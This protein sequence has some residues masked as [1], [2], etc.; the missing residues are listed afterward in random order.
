VAR[1]F[2]PRFSPL[3]T[4]SLV[5]PDAVREEIRRAFARWGLPH[6]LRVDNGVP[7][8]SWGDFPTDLSLWVIGLDVGVH[9]NNP[10]S[11]QEN[12]VVERSQGTSNRWCEPWTCGSPEELQERLDRM[13]RLYRDS[14][15]YRERLSRTAYFPGLAHSGRPYEPARESELWKWPRVAEHLAS[16]A[17]IRRVDSKGQVSLYNRG[18]YVGQIHKGKS[19][20]IMF[21]PN[22]QELVFADRDGQQL[23]TLPAEML[24]P[25]RVMDLEVTHR[26]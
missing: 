12:G 1:C 4:W 8:G 13:D 2:T 23:R 6:R 3:G 15:P 26:R 21:D 7:W 11:P 22:R 17:V 20:H 9:W 10:R 19:V 24:S 16:Y 25:Q 14:Y 5:T 18:L